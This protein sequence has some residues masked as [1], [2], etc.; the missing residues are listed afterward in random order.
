MHESLQFFILFFSNKKRGIFKKKK[1]KEIEILIP[2]IESFSYSNK[3]KGFFKVLTRFN[4]I[5]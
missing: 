1:L 5:F 3:K 4:E 2:L